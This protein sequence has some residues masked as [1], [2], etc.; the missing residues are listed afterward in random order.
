MAVEER[1][2]TSLYSFDLNLSFSLFDIFSKIVNGVNVIEISLRSIYAKTGIGKISSL[3]CVLHWP[4]F[5]NGLVL[6]LLLWFS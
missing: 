6:E 2:A 1:F 3:V 4:L 5:M